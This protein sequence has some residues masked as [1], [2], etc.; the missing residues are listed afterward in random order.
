VNIEKQIRQ[1]VQEEVERLVRPLHAAIEEL[2]DHGGV[3]AQL[4]TLLG[5]KRRGPGRP[6]NLFKVRAAVV[7]R[8]GK[9]SRAPN[10]END[11][12]C[13]LIGCKRPARS[14]GYCAAHYQKYRNLS[15]TGRLPAE[16]VPFAPPSSVKDLVLPRGRAGAQA[17]A[18]S[19]KKK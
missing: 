15:K 9:R 12:P 11:R 2:R 3:L 8:K 10:G 4:G 5:G 19:R 7:G 14:K 16:W 13:A 1:I 6:A 18:A 17:L